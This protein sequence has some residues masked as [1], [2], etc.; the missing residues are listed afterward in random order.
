MKD[1]SQKIS[2]RIVTH[3]KIFLGTIEYSTSTGLIEDVKEGID[4]DSTQYS[5]EDVM[6]FPGFGDIH[7]HAREDVSGKHTYKEDFVSSGYAAINGGVIHV[8]DMPNNPIPPVD[9]QSYK[10]KRRINT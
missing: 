3:E 1:N 10:K 4:S 7:I 8:A 2:G 5:Q 9:D 6:I